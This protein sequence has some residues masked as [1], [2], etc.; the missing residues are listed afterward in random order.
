MILPNVVCSIF[1]RTPSWLVPEEH[2]RQR[3]NMSSSK[4][5]SKKRKPSFEEVEEEEIKTY[6][7]EHVGREVIPAKRVAALNKFNAEHKK[8]V[9]L[10]EKHACLSVVRLSSD[11]LFLT[12]SELNYDNTPVSGAS[13]MSEKSP[14]KDIEQLLQYRE[15]I[16]TINLSVILKVLKCPLS[17]LKF[18]EKIMQN[19]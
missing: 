13:T 15:G 18:H 12:L 17:C 14:M 4:T 19:L 6:S 16:G 11:N 1:D 10:L 2:L 9:F 7:Y 3:Q 5:A 8:F